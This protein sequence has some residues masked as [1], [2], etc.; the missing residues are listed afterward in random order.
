MTGKLIVIGAVNVGGALQ[1]QKGGTPIRLLGQMGA[2]HS[3]LAPQVPAFK[4]QGFDME[5]ASLRGA[6]APKGLP[7]SVRTQLVD[8]IA[9]IASD[10][11]FQ[12]QAEAMFAPLRYLPPGPYAA[13]IERAEA[14]FRQ[15]WKDMPWQEDK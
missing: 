6:A 9:R 1:Y 12:Q 3:V 14:G 13:E 7:E 15:L 10:P 11:Q 8:A 4:E 5:L 2:S